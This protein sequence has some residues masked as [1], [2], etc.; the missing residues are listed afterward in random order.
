MD[1]HSEQQ[2]V[3]VPARTIANL[4]MRQ[5]FFG[6]SVI[7]ICRGMTGGEVTAFF[8]DGFMCIRSWSA[9]TGGPEV[10]P[11]WIYQTAGA[12]KLA[13]PAHKDEASPVTLKVDNNQ[14]ARWITDGPKAAPKSPK[15][16]KPPKSPK[17][18]KLS[19]ALAPAPA[20]AKKRRFVFTWVEGMPETL[21]ILANGCPGTL[22]LRLVPLEIKCAVSGACMSPSAF[23]AFAGLTSRR[24]WRGSIHVKQ[25]GAFPQTIGRYLQYLEQ[26][27]AGEQPSV[28]LHRSEEPPIIMASAAAA[29]PPPPTPAAAASPPHSPFAPPAPTTP[30]R[31]LD[32]GNRPETV[33][34]TTAHLE[35]SVAD[36]QETGDAADSL[37]PPFS[38]C[39][40]ATAGSIMDL[41]SAATAAAP[42]EPSPALPPVAG[43]PAWA[44]GTPPKEQRKRLAWSVST[45]V[46]HTGMPTTVSV[47]A[48]RH[49]GQLLLDRTPMQV[50]CAVT[51][52]C[53]LPKVFKEAAG[54]DRKKHWPHTIYVEGRLGASRP[55]SSF[56]S[57]C[58]A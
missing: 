5:V 24:N 8:V 28:V 32:F 54:I 4:P 52:K 19:G 36:K 53:M 43:N 38:P 26:A 42:I 23:E 11:P 48:N 47:L 17:L 13:T 21:D 18:P 41:S 6:H 49:R 20:G 30:G 1:T 14:F 44:P 46:W 40:P 12:I 10:L 51:G 15:S 3:E 25:R 45:F 22:Q 7:S 55:P 9:L 56:T 39:A 33:A 37:H 29:A 35:E 34:A 2:P 58:F 27:H 57:L 16:P 31:L 50:Q